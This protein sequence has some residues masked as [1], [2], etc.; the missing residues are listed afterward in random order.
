VVELP[1]EE[2]KRDTGF[3]QYPVED[4][5]EGTEGRNREAR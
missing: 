1:L 4:Q 2:E 3:D 5:R